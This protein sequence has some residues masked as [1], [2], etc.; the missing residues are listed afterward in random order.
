MKNPNKDLP[1]AERL[2]DY[3]DHLCVFMTVVVPGTFTSVNGVSEADALAWVYDEGEWHSL[4]NTPIWWSNVAREL[5][6]QLA[7]DPAEAVGGF[8][9]KGGNAERKGDFYWLEAAQDGPDLDLLKQWEK[10]NAATF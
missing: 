8:L 3:V 6:T 2:S 4:G 7:D 10:E 5:R 9:R 1:P